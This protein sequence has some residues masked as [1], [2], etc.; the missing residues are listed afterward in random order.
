[1]VQSLRFS[2]TQLSTKARASSRGV[3]AEFLVKVSMVGLRGAVGR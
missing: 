2:V 3:D 1:M